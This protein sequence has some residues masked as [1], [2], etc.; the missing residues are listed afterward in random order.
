MNS[1]EWSL[2]FG[3]VG[4]TRGGR[5]RADVRGFLIGGVGWGE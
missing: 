1:K 2:A 4:C 5:A 3:L